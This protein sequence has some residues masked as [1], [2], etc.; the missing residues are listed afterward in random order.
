MDTMED[1]LPC[2]K[3]RRGFMKWFIHKGH[4]GKDVGAVGATGLYEKDLTLKLAK[5]LE[6][7]G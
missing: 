2:K 3:G 1:H 7:H 6:V 5:I 4:G